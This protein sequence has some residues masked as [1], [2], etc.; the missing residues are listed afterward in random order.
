ERVEVEVQPLDTTVAGQDS[1]TVQPVVSTTYTLTA[2]L[3]G[4]E[5]EVHEVT[6]T[7]LEEPDGPGGVNVTIDG[8]ILTLDGAMLMAAAANEQGRAAL[9]ELARASNVVPDDPRVHLMDGAY[10]AGLASTWLLP[11]EG[12]P[13]TIAYLGAGIRTDHEDIGPAL[14]QGYDFCADLTCSTTDDSVHAE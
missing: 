8:S 3:A 12:E 4:Y 5:P 9:L 7:V 14:L 2:R 13:V 1:V 6:L 10:F 11:H